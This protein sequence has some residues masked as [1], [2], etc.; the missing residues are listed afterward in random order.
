M[1]AKPAGMPQGDFHD[2]NAAFQQ[3]IRQWERLESTSEITITGTTREQKV[4]H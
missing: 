3:C 1:A 4:G 2:I